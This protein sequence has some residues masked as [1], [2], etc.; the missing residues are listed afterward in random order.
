MGNREKRDTCHTQGSMIQKITFKTDILELKLSAKFKGA[1][2]E[3]HIRK[4]NCKI[5]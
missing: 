4:K 1:V 2:L 5:F 3:C